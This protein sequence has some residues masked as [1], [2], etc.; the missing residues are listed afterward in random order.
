[1]SENLKKATELLNRIEAAENEGFDSGVLGKNEGRTETDKVSDGEK[2]G[3]TV[4]AIVTGGASLLLSAP[5]LLDRGE[6]KE[7]KAVL[8]AAYERGHERGDAARNGKDN[9]ITVRIKR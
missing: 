8:D 1:M 3:H 5:M 9:D 7:T 4:A 6:D 2:L